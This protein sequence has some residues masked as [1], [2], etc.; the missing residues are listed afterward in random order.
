MKNNYPKILIIGQSFDDKTGGGITLSNIFRGWPLDKIAVVTKNIDH[1]QTSSCIKYYRLG[2]KER[3]WL[4]PLSLIYKIN[5]KSGPVDLKVNAEQLSTKSENKKRIKKS[6]RIIKILKK[7]LEN[8]GFTYLFSDF[9]ISDKFIEWTNDYSPDLIY[10]QLGSIGM[11]HFVSQFLEKI[12]KPYVIH[13]MDD[14]PVKFNRKGFFTL[15]IRNQTNRILNKLISNSNGL[16]TIC[17]TM[18]NEYE[19][20]YKKNSVPIH[21]PVDIPVWKEFAKDEWKIKDEFRI[22]FTGKLGRKSPALYEMSETVEKLNNKGVK[23]CF[24]IYTKDFDSEEANIL[25][26]YSGVKIYNSIPHKEIPKLLSSFDILFLP[27]SFDPIYVRNTRLSMPTKT[28][29]YM[30]SGTPILVYASDETALYKYADEKKWAYIVSIRSVDELTSAIMN[31]YENNELR[32][33]YGRKAIEIASKN[34]DSI[35]VRDIFR[36]CLIQNTNS[37]THN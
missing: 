12:K 8:S 29:E 34:H 22:L 19:T 35:I 5:T 4:F 31:L 26:K 27:L 14:W 32:E 7:L 2:S 9:H 30:I 10:T 18:S 24:E 20:R 33:K 3:K 23:T 21:N 36:K 17:Q 6:K 11:N 15:F 13:F 37:Y 28:S 1:T 16:L 25:R